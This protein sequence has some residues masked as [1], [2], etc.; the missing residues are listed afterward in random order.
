MEIAAEKLVNTSRGIAI[1]S[2][3]GLMTS[4]EAVRG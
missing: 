1:T 4:I 3:V 2:A